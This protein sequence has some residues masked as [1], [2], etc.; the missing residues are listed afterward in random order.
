M[1]TAAHSTDKD[2][3][4]RILALAA[5]FDFEFSINWLQGLSQDKPQLILEA[6]DLGLKNSWLA[7]EKPGFYRFV[8]TEEQIRL[9]D[10]L[11]LNERKKR[12]AIIAEILLAEVLEDP[13]KNSFLAQSLLNLEN[14]I[15]GC[16]RLLA[17]GKMAARQNR[18]QQAIAYYAKAIEDLGRLSGE[19]AD[20]LLL[21][22]TIEYAVVSLNETG[23]A[24][25]ISAIHGALERSKKPRF[26]PY[27]A[28]LKMHLAEY[29]F[30]GSEFKSA[31]RSFEEGL[32][33]AEGITDGRF[34]RAINFL[35]AAFHYWQGNY[36]EGLDLYEELAPEIDQVPQ[37]GVPIM[38]RPLHGSCLVYCGQISQ[39]LG[40]V[41]ATI[42][43]GQKLGSHRISSW[44][45]Y[46]MGHIYNEIGRFDEAVAY[47]ESALKKTEAGKYVHFKAGVLICL[48]Y[49]NHKLGRNKPAVTALAEFQKLRS[50]VKV[51]S[52]Q[53][54]WVMYLSWF[55]E[56]GKLP[57]V[58]GF[59]SIEQAISNAL[60]STNTHMKGMGYRYR[61][62]VKKRAGAPER[63]V[64]N[65]YKTALKWLDVSGHKVSLSTV[66]LELAAEYLKSGNE[67]Q[68]RVLGDPSIK[69]LATVNRNLI[70]KALFQLEREL[71]TSEG[72]LKEI[73]RLGQELT[74]VRD[75]QKLVGRIISTANRLTGAERGA[76]FRL[77]KDQEPLV[78]QASKNL[79]PEDV[80]SSDFKNSM[81]MIMETARSGSGQATVL[82]PTKSKKTSSRNFASACICVPMVLRNSVFG[83]LYHDHFG[84]QVDFQDADLEV[85]NYFAAQAAI[86]MDNA[87]AYQ[88]LEEGAEKREEEKQY[89]KAQYLEDLSFE[90]IVG[91]SQ[92][93]KKVFHHI[94]SV[95]ETDTTVLVQ[96]ET[97]VGKELVARAIH[98]NSLRKERPFIRVNCS[99]FSENLISS[100][101]FG[102]EKGA[103]T[104]AYERSVGRFELADGGTL[105]L[106]EI[107]DIPAE[108]Q[109]RLLRVLQSKEFERVGGHKTLRSDFRLLAATNKSLE[110]EVQAGRFR[111]D[112]YFR[113]N[114]FPIHVPALR[115]RKEDIPLLAYHF[116]TLN[117]KKMGK[118]IEQISKSDLE[119]LKGYHWPGNIRELENIIERGVI[120]SHGP[121]LQLPDTGLKTADGNPDSAITTLEENERSHIL[122]ALK[123]TGGQLAGKG[124]AAEILNIKPSTLRHRMKKLGIQKSDLTFIYTQNDSSS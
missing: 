54:P 18:E 58:K 106:D 17:E 78:L 87:L 39:G 7:T 9:K 20:R 100:E 5:L 75:H 61:A 95:T 82:K 4:R 67:E 10:S 44:A 99:A 21:E 40:M 102:H 37:A 109:V 26:Q 13:D 72:M 65:A 110:K 73:F 19:E 123:E 116:L 97:G 80:S 98:R 76:I 90:D 111:Q 23:S 42:D 12:Y 83:V 50:Q 1:T 113:L 2:I 11:S 49:A 69:F 60:K 105:F 107:G 66:R 55:M 104:G 108:T 79:T 41:R 45:E 120:L 14:N 38:L 32:A 63:E 53:I 121:N 84:S 118:T 25:V 70:P 101:L 114:V 122:R 43:L 124:G 62:L 36:R 68:A 6:L 28:L 33:L 85:L 27:R 92:A 86:A 112:L 71:R 35:S 34:K 91:R 16:R 8:N 15:D 94:E 96:G 31:Q 46:I 117:T 57:A 115:D 51:H 119:K 77:Q 93:I 89:Y 48:A 47:L 3:H 29:E 103:F 52:T 81:K 24:Q 22:T 30:F 74:T 56:Q 88:A 59:L 64:I